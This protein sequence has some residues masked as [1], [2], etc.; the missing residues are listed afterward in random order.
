MNPNGSV[1]SEVTRSTGSRCLCGPGALEAQCHVVPAA[2][3]STVVRLGAQ[4]TRVVAGLVGVGV[5]ETDADGNPHR[6]PR[7][8]GGASLSRRRS[9][10]AA[11]E[12]DLLPTAALPDA[13]QILRSLLPACHER[14][15]KQR[16]WT[17]S[18][19]VTSRRSSK[20]FIFPVQRWWPGTVKPSTFRFSGLR[21]SVRFRSAPSVT[22]ARTASR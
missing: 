7:A 4:R 14:Q 2:V 5:N 22:C 6:G 21:C 15:R 3:I 8:A 1:S 11:E 12:P 9:R 20:K 10:P 16:N 18:W 17:V 19:T 13:S